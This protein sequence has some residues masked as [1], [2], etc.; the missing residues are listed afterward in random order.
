MKA[1][2]VEIYDDR[3][4]DKPLTHITVPGVIVPDQI[5]KELKVGLTIRIDLG[6]KTKKKTI[7]INVYDEELKKA[8]E[9][10]INSM[11]LRLVI[12]STEESIGGELKISEIRS[13]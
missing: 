7:A 5:S 1:T 11:R 6:D 8:I 9:D 12:L 13:A 4:G 10:Y 3:A 2:R